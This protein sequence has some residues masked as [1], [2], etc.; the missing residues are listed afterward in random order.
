[1]GDMVDVVR[2]AI[3][4]IDQPAILGIGSSTIT[5]LLTQEGVV[6]EFA[7]QNTADFVLGG[8]VGFRDQVGRGFFAG[9]KAVDPIK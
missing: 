3:E 6:G 2:G 8:Q 7:Q 1:M 4:R 9:G 5:P